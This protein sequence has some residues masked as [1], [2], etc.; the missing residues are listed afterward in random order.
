MD[1]VQFRTRGAGNQL[2]AAVIAVKC[3][4]RDD[5]GTEQ[6]AVWVEESEQVVAKD[7]EIHRR[8]DSGAA[9]RFAVLM[10]VI[11]I[12]FSSMHLSIVP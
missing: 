10:E 12:R 2:S 7:T 4:G 9:L 11:S 5:A 8:M 1:S 6:A 3:T